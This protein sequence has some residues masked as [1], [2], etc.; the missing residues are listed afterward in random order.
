MFDNRKY[1]QGMISEEM[2]ITDREK[3][4]GYNQKKF[5]HNIDTFYYSVKFKNDFRLKTHDEKVL[6][7]RRYFKFKYDS[8]GDDES[9]GDVY[10]KQIDKRLIL[11]P[12]TFS[13]FYNTCLSYPD[14]FDIFLASVVPKSMGG[15]ESVTCEMIVQIRSYMLW[16]FGIHAAFENSYRV[17]KNLAEYF[18][19]EIDFVQENRVDYCWH[20]NYLKNPEAFF[21]PENFYK[22]RVDRFK[23]ATYVT[24]KIGSEDYEI[25]Y[26]A[27]GKRSDKV[28]VR[29]YQK[30]REVIEQNYKPWFFQIWKM[31]GLI[32]NYDL[33]VYERCF[34]KK[35]WFHRFYAR[36]E[37]YADYGSNP[38]YVDMCR[39][40]VMENVTI[41]ED[42]LI[43]LAKLL[44]PELNLVVNVEYQTMRRHSKS[45]DLIPFKDNSH[46]GE[47]R[48]IY[49]YLDNRKLIMDY[50]TDRVFKLVERTG[51][52]HKYR[53]P[54]C[55]FWD[56]LRHTRCID[57][58]LT[59][60]ELKLIRNYNRKL[61]TDSMRRRVINSAVTLG[62]Y[63]RGINE[64][65]PLQDCFE[66]LLK[67]NDNDIMDAM[68]YKSK[69]IRQL[70]EDELAG[71]FEDA[72]THSFEV[73]RTETGD[74]YDNSMLSCLFCQ[75]GR[76][77]NDHTGGV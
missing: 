57:V 39:D 46:T 73:I 13:R 59:P 67:M 3:W 16:M 41:G 50:L 68:R 18:G 15:G 4:F 34:Q 5:I 11:R 8:L 64:D 23:N 31:N 77:F 33:Y 43:K 51:D 52:S 6:R 75:D 20:S 24:N 17:V 36:I 9:A 22:M 60:D 30:T 44:T 55:G 58:K 61:N 19:L 32:N 2:C 65:N 40:I 72:A 27:L 38:A 28:F 12:V 49:D 29:I 25:D 53:R 70:N 54:L 69:K 45:Y 1:E 63:T 66:A 48:R 21:T 35:S 62:F 7:L 47:C 71:V 10:L 37:F 42:D 14:Y 56:A 26:V 74:I 76:D